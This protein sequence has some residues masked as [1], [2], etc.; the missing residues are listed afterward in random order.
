MPW[1]LHVHSPLLPSG[2][3]SPF[4]GSSL[5]LSPVTCEVE[6]QPGRLVCV[7]EMVGLGKNWG[8]HRRGDSYLLEF[9]VRGMNGVLESV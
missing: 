4:C 6:L 8:G 7:Y 9:S 1:P 2:N 3:P 5:L